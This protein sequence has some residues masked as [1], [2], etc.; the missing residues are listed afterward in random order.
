MKRISSDTTH[1]KFLDTDNAMGLRKASLVLLSAI[2]FTLSGYAQDTVEP[3]LNSEEV[4]LTSWLDS[5]E[6]NMLDMLERITNINSGSLNKQGVNELASIFS[7]ELRQLG[8]AISTLPG[9]V[10]E[11]PSCPGSDYNVDVADHVLASKSGS[12][13]KLLMMGHF[14]TVFPY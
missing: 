6:E 3:S 1:T 10:I 9:E 8:F 7:E 13:S 11:M 5:Q 12:G 14:D 2:L 4:E